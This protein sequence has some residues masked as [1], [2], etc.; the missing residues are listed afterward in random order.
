MPILPVTDLRFELWLLG[1]V[2]RV[3]YDQ[4]ADVLTIIAIELYD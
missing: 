4:E 1:G 2:V 3:E